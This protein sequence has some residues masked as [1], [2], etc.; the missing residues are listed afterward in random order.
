M[1]VELLGCDELAPIRR[2]FLSGELR[3]NGL[4]LPDRS[5]WAKLE[6][7]MGVWVPD[8]R[9]PEYT[10]AERELIDTLLLV[11]DELQRLREVIGQVVMQ[12]SGDSPESGQRTVRDLRSAAEY[13]GGSTFT[14]D[15]IHYAPGPN[16]THVCASYW[17][18]RSPWTTPALSKPSS[19]VFAERYWP[20]WLLP[21][22]SSPCARWQCW[23]A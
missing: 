10:L 2:A 20:Y 23:P 17:Y 8:P 4:G 1:L 13:L 5:L 9:V 7:A 6:E 19:P 11:I 22:P 18:D 21:K 3:L 12:P 14:T 15:P 16:K